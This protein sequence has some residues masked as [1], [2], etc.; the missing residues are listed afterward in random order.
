MS[1]AKPTVQKFMSTGVKTID[2]KKNLK[3]A[4]SRMEIEGVRHLPVTLDGEVIGILS[5]R[6]IKSALGLIGIDPVKTLIVDI[7][8]DAVYSVDPDTHLD[9]VADTMAQEHYGSAVV[10]QNNK[11]VGIITMVDICKAL[12]FIIN[13]RFHSQ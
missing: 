7:C 1:K 8:K 9:I 11:L 4:V 12:S 5:E 6:D 2:G 10:M 3:E 13:E